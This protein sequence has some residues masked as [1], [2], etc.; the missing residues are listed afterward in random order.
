MKK[1]FLIFTMSVLA[2]T[3]CTKDNVT[4]DNS[5]FPNRIGNHW[6]YKYT[7]SGAATSYIDVD[8]IGQATLPD[9]QNAKIWAYKILTYTDTTYVVSDDQLV[10]IYD[11]PCWTCTTQMPYERQRY[12]L[13]LQTGNTWFTNST[14]GDTTKVITQSALTV[15]AGTFENTYEL[16]KKRGYVTNSWTSNQIWLTPNV[17]LTKL[18]QGEYSL[19]PVLGN[20][21]WEL[22][23]YSLK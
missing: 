16:F 8:I 1:Y 9:G 2:F 5:T 10:K 23:N 7:A 3:S 15:P 22:D 20:G 19:G 21:L 11:K 18:N 13:P 12:V 14:F 6:H 17:G 4:N